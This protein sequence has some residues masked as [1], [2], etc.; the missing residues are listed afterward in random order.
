MFCYVN[1]VLK[2]FTAYDFPILHPSCM[3]HD[4]TISV[5][6]CTVKKKST[7]AQSKKKVQIVPG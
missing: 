2:M 3:D 4:L 6:N 7:I 1:F 5:Y